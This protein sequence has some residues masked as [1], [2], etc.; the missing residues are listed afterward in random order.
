MTDITVICPSR[1]RPRQAKMLFESFMDTRTSDN[2]RLHFALD[3]TDTTADRYPPGW[4]RYNSRSAPEA[5]N[6]A[7]FGNA[8][9]FNGKYV[10]ALCDEQR[11]IT[12]GW[13]ELVLAALDEQGGGMVFPNDLI[14]PGTMPANPYISSVIPLAVGYFAY[15]E[16]HVNYYDNVWKALGEGVGKIRYLPDVVVQHLSMPHK[17]DNSEAIADD[18]KAYQRWVRDQ[19]DSDVAKAKAALS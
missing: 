9:I 19:R 14:N 6:K 7:F 8:D 16:C 12:Q 17:V 3:E 2:V 5:L 13:D 1:E 15:P 18:R 4:K 11:F 10:S